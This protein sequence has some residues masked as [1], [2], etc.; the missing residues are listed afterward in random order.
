MNDKTPLRELKGVGEKT[1]KLFQKIGITTAEELLRYYPRTYDIYEEPVEIASAEEDKTVSI[2]AT[3]ATGIYINQI[4]NLQVLTTTVADASGR[5]PVAWFNAPYLRG[6][7]KK[8]SV[9]ILRGKIIRK[10]GRPQME[11]PEIFTPAAYEEIIHSMQPVYGLTKGLSNKMITKLVHQI[12]DTRPL[13]G[14]YLPEEIRER[15]QLADANYAIRTIHFP[16][17]MQELLTARKRLV[18]DEFLLFVLAIQ[19]LKEKTEE[20][21]NTFPMKP[22]WTTEEII[23]G[24]PYDLT[25]AQK[26]VWHEIER[27]LSGHKLMSRLVQG[28]VGSGKTVIAFL[29]MV[30]SAENGFQ[31]ALMVPTEV[32]ANQHYE[33]FLRL[34]EEQN[35]ASCHPVLLTGSTTARQKREIYQ[36]IADGEVNVIIGTHALIQEKVEYKNLGLVITDEQHRFGVR[37]R[38]ALTTRGNPPHVLVMSATPIPRTLAIILYGDLDISIIDELPAKR[39]PIKNCVVGTSYR[40]KAYSFIEKQ[41]QMG[42]QAYV[43]CPMVEESEGLEAENVTD[44]ARKLQ[45]V[46]PGEIKVEILHGKMKPKEKNRIM[47][48]FAS[49]EIQVLVST[50]VV[51]VGVNVPN[52]TVMMVENAERFGLA[53]L[54]QLR[55]RV[56]RGEHQ[57]YCIFIQGNNEENTS[58]RLKILNESNDGFY[59]AGEDLKLRGPGDLFGIR[60]SGLMEF[61]IGDIYNDAGILKNASEAAGEILALDFDL[62]LPQHKALKEHLKGYMSEELENLGI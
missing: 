36:K 40:P 10:K 14:E 33:G 29:A 45:E 62:I 60:Q 57:S 61:K 32:L 12:L 53:Q 28:D 48:A 58:K 16:K 13:H 44:Y 8:G 31:S 34:M 19:L 17:N 18:F 15:Y 30:L 42:R 2:R 38:E 56:G 37:Q 43:I 4:R 27:D 23:E 49:G 55:G 3:I 26:N 25:G 59:I 20:A 11:H 7:L 5:L 22:V 35:I 24:L 1:E 46:L 47:E 39:L 52:A 21:P 51:E 54:H 50:T 9:F 41:V 6:T